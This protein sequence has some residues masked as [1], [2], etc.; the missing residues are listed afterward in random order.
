[1]IYLLDG[2]ATILT[3]SGGLQKEAYILRTPCVTLRTETEWVETV[4][5]GWNRLSTP[6][7]LQTNINLAMTTQSPEHP[8]FYGAGTAASQMVN[9]LRNSG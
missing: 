7:A 3:D 8:A 1:M 4:S 2:A 5:S 6:A 9:C